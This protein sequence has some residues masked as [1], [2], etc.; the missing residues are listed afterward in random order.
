MESCRC[1]SCTNS[2]EACSEICAGEGKQ[3]DQS[4]CTQSVG[5]CSACVCIECQSTTYSSCQSQCTQ[6]GKQIDQSYCTV[7]VV[8]HVS[9]PVNHMIMTAV[10]HNAINRESSWI[11]HIAPVNV[12]KNVNV[13]AQSIL[14]MTINNVK[15]CVKQGIKLSTKKAL[16]NMDAKTVVAS[17]Q[18]LLLGHVKPSAT[19]RE[20]YL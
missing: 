14:L 10:N 1:I 9:V 3:V 2:S 5:C 8:Q 11:S 13:N 19:Q 6:Q 12:V 17:V 7:N 4:Y 15:R 18:H 20:N 16:I